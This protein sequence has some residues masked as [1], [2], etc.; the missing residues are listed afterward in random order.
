MGTNFGLRLASLIALP[1]PRHLSARGPDP[2]RWGAHVDRGTG[3]A[4]R[5]EPLD[6]TL[7]VLQAYGQVQPWVLLINTQV[8]QT[9]SALYACHNWIEQKLRGG[10]V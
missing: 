7:I 10:G 4:F 8:A 1:A 3:R 6:G 9:E 2:T 5:E